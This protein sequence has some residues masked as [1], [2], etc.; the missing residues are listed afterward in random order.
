MRRCSGP[1]WLYLHFP[2]QD[3]C[4]IVCAGHSIVSDSLACPWNSLGKDTGV[5]KKRGILAWIA[6]P[7][8]RGHSQPRDQTQVS[9]ITGR[10]FT[11]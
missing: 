4:V 2:Y 6:I 7:F 5:E 9:C 10:F 1:L 8:S 3:Y 11:I